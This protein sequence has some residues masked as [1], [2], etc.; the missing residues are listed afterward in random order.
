MH[1]FV[2][3]LLHV[4]KL[5]VRTSSDIYELFLHYIYNIFYFHPK[6]KLPDPP[7][8][9]LQQDVVENSGVP[10]LL[11]AVSSRWPATS[12]ADSRCWQVRHTRCVWMEILPE[13][14]VMPEI[15]ASPCPG[16]TMML[17]HHG[18]RTLK[19]QVLTTALARHLMMHLQ[20]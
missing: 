1:L 16:V 7:G 4:Q 8:C 10:L 19:A 17:L 14:P 9:E 3:T 18:Y 11:V 2:I 12:C 5:N 6:T 13:S 20:Q 15:I